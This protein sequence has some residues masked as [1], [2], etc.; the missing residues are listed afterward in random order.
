MFLSHFTSIFLANPMDRGAWQVVVHR[1]PRV[2]PNLV[3]KPANIDAKKKK[4]KNLEGRVRRKIKE[5]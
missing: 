5:E 2:G 1:V 3:T 4:K